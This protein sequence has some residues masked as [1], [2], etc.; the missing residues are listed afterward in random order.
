E[1]KKDGLII[2]DGESN[3]HN[4]QLIEKL[5]ENHDY[6]ILA[7]GSSFL[8]IVALAGGVIGESREKGRREIKIRVSR[9][10]PLTTELRTCKV[11]KTSE[12]IVRELPEIFRATAV[13]Y[14]SKFEIIEDL[15]NPLFGVHF[16]PEL[17]LDGIKILKNFINFVEVWKK[18]H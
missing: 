10:C 13:S 4:Q 11:V 3:R 5:L 17:G 1:V 9:A 12:F 18:Y 14:E 8:Y 7:I 2:S 15:E 16:N 6:P